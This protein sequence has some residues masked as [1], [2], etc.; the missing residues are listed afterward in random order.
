MA[1]VLRKGIDH[2][3]SML[4]LNL[5]HRLW[6]GQLLLLLL[7][8]LYWRSRLLLWLHLSLLLWLHLSLLL[9]LSSVSRSNGT[10][11]LRFQTAQLAL[12]K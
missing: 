4:S 2:T 5:L 12:C 9:C 3:L 6:L 7:L 8:R 1:S 11:S 10:T